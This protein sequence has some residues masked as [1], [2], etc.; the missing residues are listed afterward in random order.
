MRRM[1]TSTTVVMALAAT[2]AGCGANGALSTARTAAGFQAAS[3]VDPVDPPLDRLPE[4]TLVV[5]NAPSRAPLP[6]T[7]GNSGK[8]YVSPAETEP[9]VEALIK[10]AKHSVYLETFNFGWES[11]GQKLV[12]LLIERAKA[13]VEVKLAI[14]YIGSRFLS[15]HKQMLKTLRAGGVD[16]R[17]YRTRTIIKDDHRIG[18]NITHRKVYLADGQH[19]LIGGV[20]LMKDFDTTTQDVLIDWRG[21]VVAQLYDEFGR[22]WRSA[23]GGELKQAAVP[24]GNQ[25]HVD[26]QVILTSPGEGRFEAKEVIYHQLEIAKREILIEQQYV[27]D[28]GAIARLH[29]AVK[30]GVKVRIMVPGKEAKGVFK[31]IH[32]QEMKRLMDEGAQARLYLGVPASAHLHAKYVNVDDQW[33]MCGSINLDTRALIEN[34]ELAVAFTDRELIQNMRQRLFERD[35]AQFS[36]PLVYEEGSWV[37]KPVRSLLELIDYY[38]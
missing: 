8:L 15:G 33:T 38:L 29:A 31:N 2:L 7:H 17:V 13:G 12:P 21:P 23:G 5:P 26:A 37:L 20:N 32:M 24:T 14:D 36:E 4:E 35:W 18:V 34:Q 9:A 19:A 11:Y 30:R 3:A 16:V 6:V 28:D 25:G 27:F 1:L 22:D 10:G